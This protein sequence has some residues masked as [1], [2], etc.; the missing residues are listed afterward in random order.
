VVFDPCPLGVGVGR[1]KGIYAILPSSSW[2]IA[3]SA[4]L[5]LRRSSGDGII[6]LA[7]PGVLQI[8]L[9]EVGTG[10]AKFAVPLIVRPKK[11]CIS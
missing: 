2:V 10:S 7:L 5:A 6:V 4:V 9:F 3:L 11:W 8:S 1:P